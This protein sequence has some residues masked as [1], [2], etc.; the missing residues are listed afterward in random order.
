MINGIN[1]YLY[2]I[3]DNLGG[4]PNIENIDCGIY[5]CIWVHIYNNKD[6]VG[7]LQLSYI[8]LNSW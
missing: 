5:V 8:Y 6:R 2:N 7:L 4:P 1:G 3:Q